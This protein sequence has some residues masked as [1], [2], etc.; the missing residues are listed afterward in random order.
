M[1]FWYSCLYE[2]VVCANDSEL[3]RKDVEEIKKQYKTEIAIA[4]NEADQLNGIEEKSEDVFDYGQEIDIRIGNVEELKTRVAKLLITFLDIENDN[5]SIVLSYSEISKKIRKSKSKE[6]EKLVKD[7]GGIDNDERA[8]EKMFMKYKIG[9]W[10]IG[11]QK[12]LVKYDPKTYDREIMENDM[13]EYADNGMEAD[14]LVNAENIEISNEYDNEGLE[15]QQFGEDYQ[16][17]DFYGDHRED[18]NDFGDW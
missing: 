13:E 4:N 17:G 8:I 9:R 3:L 14:E 12:G 7:L 2:Y 5:K 6:K 1:Y 15:I 11:L 10:N 16:D 18:E